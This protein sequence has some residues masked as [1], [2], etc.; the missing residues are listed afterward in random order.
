MQGGWAVSLDA[1]TVDTRDQ[2]RDA[3]LRSTDF[4]DVE[5]FSKL[6][7]VSESVSAIDL[8]SFEVFGPARE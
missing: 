1:S 2:Q 5:R 4:L 7:F 8:G 6:Q 3:H